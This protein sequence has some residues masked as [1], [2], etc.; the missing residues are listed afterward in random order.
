MEKQQNTKVLLIAWGGADWELCRTLVE[1]G[2]LP[3][4][5]RL[6]AEGASG[7][8]TSLQ[9]LIGPITWTSAATGKYPSKHGI[10]G[11]YQ[12]SPDGDGICPARSTSRKTKAIWNILSQRGLEAHSINWLVSHPA[13]PIRGVCVSQSFAAQPAAA[14]QEWPVPAGSVHPAEVLETLANLRERPEDLDPGVIEAFV[15]DWRKVNQKSDHR[16]T[17]CMVF[18]AESVTAHSTAT[19][20]LEHRPWNFLAAGYWGIERF[21]HRFMPFHPPRASYVSESD[22]A[23]YNGVVEG[24]YVFHDMMLGRLLELAGADANV[25]LVSDHGYW[26]GDQ[27]PATPPSNVE[28]VEGLFRPT[29]FCVMHGR[30]VK[31]GRLLAPASLLDVTPTILRL[32]GLPV[33][34][35]M[36]GGGWKSVVAAPESGSPETIASWDLVPGDSGMHPIENSN[37]EEDSEAA[38]SHL[39]ELGYRVPV[40]DPVVATIERTRD[41][42]RFNLVRSLASAG[43]LR[44]AIPI[45]EKLLARHPRHF[46]WGKLLFEMYLATEQ[47]TEARAIAARAIGLGGSGPEI[48]LAHLGLGI[49]DGSEGID[50]S[51]HLKQ[52]E[53]L[54]SPTA[55]YLVLVGQAYAQIRR[56]ADAKRLFHR[57]VQLDDRCDG[58]CLGL[59]VAANAERDYESAAVHAQRAIILCEGNAAAYYQLGMAKFQLGQNADAAR[60]LERCIELRPRMLPAYRKLEEIYRDYLRDPLRARECWR[61][62]HLI[63][64]QRRMDRRHRDP[65]VSPPIP[66]Q[67][68]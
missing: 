58:A 31:S 36:D 61:Q 18:L 68:I 9:P 22:F 54:E 4:L 1:R 17:D 20:V 25:M 24:A 50:A 52:A 65:A 40:E 53:L 35:D 46:A 45:L 32:F 59:A 16:L 57:A 47:F 38:I 63:M 6:I 34:S 19:W 2:R 67:A 60:A 33:G 23:L 14:G 12:M 10:H 55:A 43:R 44:Q 64:L 37:L 7:P 3:H 11:H 56:W 30:G 49:L 51:D 41:Q 62:A 13:E 39:L 27:R 26:T 29:G 42:N 8:L 5:G 28:E 66:Q 48:A 21:S 15:P